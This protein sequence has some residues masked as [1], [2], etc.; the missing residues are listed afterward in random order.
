M[1]KILVIDDDPIIRLFLKKVLQKQGYD[2]S[3]ATNG[4][5]GLELAQSIQ[6]GLIICD[7][8]M[9]IMDGLDVCRHVKADPNLS[10]TFFILLSSRRGLADRV[11][12]LDSG[13]DEFLSKPIEVVELQARVRAGLRL[14]QMSQD[15]QRQKQMLEAEIDEAVEYVRSLIPAPMHGA[16]SIDSCFIPSRQLGGDCFDYYWLDP[17]YLVI[18]LLDVSGHGLG[19]TLLSTAVLN[20][21]RSQSLPD[22]NFYQPHDVLRSLNDTFQM[23][24]HNEKYFTI[25]YG[26][27]NKAKRLLTYAS[28]GHPPAIMIAE[29]ADENA[30]RSAP[31]VSR[32]KTPGLPIGMMPEAV[33]Q[34]DRYFVPAN[35]SLYVFSDGIFEVG[36]LRGGTWGLNDFVGLLST[37]SPHANLQ[38]ILDVVLTYNDAESFED[39]LS[40]L[41]LN[42]E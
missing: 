20:L 36:Q 33:F 24:S 27:Y 30:L 32:L 31:T 1:L 39:D 15:L 2:V 21:L 42:F 5:E 7:W 29:S 11:Q 3:L 6:P 34:S 13:A 4:K 40:L 10:T 28:A 25:W 14:H 16:V 38:G 35:S 8:I 12:G 19:A 41:R 26:V 37:R 18:Y 22:V 9:P 17:D 23:N